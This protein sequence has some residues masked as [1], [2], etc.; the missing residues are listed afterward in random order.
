ML[1]R[2]AARQTG[3]L[4]RAA[5]TERQENGLLDRRRVVGLGQQP[6][7][8]RM[9]HGLPLFSASVSTHRPLGWRYGTTAAVVLAQRVGGVRAPDTP[10]AASAGTHAHGVSRTS[11]HPLLP[12]VRPAAAR[13][14]TRTTRMG[15]WEIPGSAPVR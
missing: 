11:T 6:R 4:A 10:Q 1:R 3:L 12:Q 15:A 5:S 13:V 14:S 8:V 2:L 7:G 9:Q